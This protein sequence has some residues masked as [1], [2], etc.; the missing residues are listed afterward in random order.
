MG[1]TASRSTTTRR[2]VM[3]SSPIFAPRSRTIGCEPNR[4]SSSSTDT[5]RRSCSG[6]DAAGGL[7]PVDDRRGAG[8]RARRPR[9]HGRPFTP[10]GAGTGLAGGAV[11]LGGPVVIVTTKMNR[12]VSVDP[13]ERVAWVEPGVINLD[14][15][16]ALAPLTGCTSRPTRRASRRAR[17]AATSP[18][19]RAVR[20][21]SPTA[22]RPRTSSPSR[23]CCPT[24]RSACSVA[25]SPSPPATTCAACSS[26]ARARWASRRRS[27]CGSRPTRPRVRT[28]L[29][30]LRVDGRR[31][32]VRERDHRRRPR[33]GRARDDGRR[34]DRGG[35]GLRARRLPDRCRGRAARRGRRLAGVRRGRRRAHPVDQRGPRRADGAGRGRRGRAAA[36]V[37]G[38][39][40]RVRRGRRA[41]RPTTTCTTRWCRAR[42]WSRC[43][44][45][46]DEIAAAHGLRVLNVFHAG[47]GNLHPLLSFDAREPGVLEQVHAAGEEIVRRLARGR[48]RAVGRARHRASRSATSWPRCS[49]ADDLDAQARLHEAFDPDGAANPGKVLPA[50]SRC[51][52]LQ[53]VSRRAVGVT[54][55][56]RSRP[57]SGESTPDRSSRSADGRS[58]TSA[59][60]SPASAREVRAP[61]GVVEHEPAEMTVRVRAGTTVAELDDALG[62]HGQCVALPASDGATVGGVARRRPQRHPPARLGPGARHA[63][64][65]CATCRPTGRLI[66][67]GRADGEERQRLRPAAGCSSARSARSGSSPR[68]CCAPGRVPACERW[69]AG[70]ADPF[71]LRRPAAPARRAVLWDGTTTWVLL[72]GHPDDVDAQGRLAGLA[73][74]RGPA[75]VA[76]RAAASL[77]DAR[78]R[79]FGRC[80]RTGTGRSSPRSASASCTAASR[81]RAPT[82][83]PRRRRRS[84]GA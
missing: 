5:T 23:S 17:S 7:L 34:H 2:D 10:R 77:V 82:A 41:S 79:S 9:R 65:R 78:R 35:R 63:C 37:E 68:S 72:D 1:G 66:K 19:T 46:V 15:H 29:R 64:S 25:S 54:L 20:T 38:S 70:E 74:G 59:D 6:G 33:A 60:R 3:R 50:G 12:I 80:R 57:R 48:R 30:R 16:A 24:A 67:G 44:A 14:L 21:A 83:R 11:P 28:L 81:S 53:R 26:A 47:D 62:E 8:V 55:D 76:A 36:A 84:T 31:R 69:F 42:V 58:S 39:Q 71:A 18:T 73:R 43:C 52:E 51:G 61:V 27:Q 4:T 13:D 22:S 32:R 75:A 40:V 56:G 45:R 49:R